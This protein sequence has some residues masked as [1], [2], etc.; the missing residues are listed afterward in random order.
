MN[1]KNLVLFFVLFLIF[2]ISILIG[3]VFS[4]E[5]QIIFNIRLPRILSV[6]LSGAMLSVSGLLTQTLFRNSIAEPYLLGISAG[7]ALGSFIGK[8]FIP[9]FPYNTQIFA[10][11][12]S[13]I[14]VFLVILISFR[15]GF[16]PRETLLLSGIALSLLCSSIL[17]FLIFISPSERIKIF[18]FFFGSFSLIEWEEF[19]I[20][21]IV[22]VI[23]IFPI[24]LNLNKF[25]LFLLSDEEVLSLGINLK[26]ERVFLSLLISFMTGV[27]TSVSGIIG[28]IGLIVP[29]IG[30]MISGSG[31][32]KNVILN[33]IITGSILLLICDDL[34]RILFKGAEI[35]VGV[36]TSLLGVPY[37]LYLLIKMKNY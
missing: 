2:I 28:F 17:S 19:F 13:Q 27:I 7:A 5:K 12:F 20:I 8:N 26:R 22:F 1:K 11:L 32:H 37:F 21:F 30:R 3:P 29:H 24:I 34:S 14:I 15:N 23:S 25:D 31:K 16:L 33:V 35:P 9:Y 18:F 6:I 36:F 4:L 10:F